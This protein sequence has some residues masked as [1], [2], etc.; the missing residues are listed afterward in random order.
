MET[1]SQ[2]A[3]K[4]PPAKIGAHC[5]HSD[6]ANSSPG[7]EWSGMSMTSSWSPH[8]WLEDSIVPTQIDP[9][10]K[11][12]FTSQ[13]AH[14]YYCPPWSLH[15]QLITFQLLPRSTIMSSLWDSLSQIFHMLPGL[16]HCIPLHPSPSFLVSE[17]CLCHDH[18]L[19]QPSSTHSRVLSIIPE[20][21]SSIQ[22]PYTHSRLRTP[23]PDHA[24][25]LPTWSGSTRPLV[26]SS[27]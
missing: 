11:E 21:T 13:S 6:F 12:I 18:D 19:L 5:W 4:C 3:I 16:F 25:S 26:P 1:E 24:R 23:V 10:P 2:L 20:P 27:R 7:S 17:F 8:S 22:K 15:L 9:F 14:S